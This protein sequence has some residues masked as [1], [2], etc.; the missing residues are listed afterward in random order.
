MLLYWHFLL[1]SPDDEETN[2][3]DAGRRDSL[4]NRSIRI[5]EKGKSWWFR[6]ASPVHKEAISMKLYYNWFA[7]NMPETTV[8]Y[9]FKI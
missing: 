2:L 7:A 4:W 9:S 3:V 6:E 1:I 5:R 8:S